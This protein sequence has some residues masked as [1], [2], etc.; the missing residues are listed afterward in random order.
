MPA[1][2]GDLG[3]GE[4]RFMLWLSKLLYGL[5]LSDLQ[6]VTAVERNRHGTKPGP[7]SSMHSSPV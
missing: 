2:L 1:K 5:P 7:C 6:V 3:N 4:F